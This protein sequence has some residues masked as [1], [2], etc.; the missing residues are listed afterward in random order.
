MKRFIDRSVGVYFLAHP[1]YASMTLDGLF[2]H[3][4][5]L[6]KFTKTL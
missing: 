6:C 5:C 2:M 3:R 4:R 1:V